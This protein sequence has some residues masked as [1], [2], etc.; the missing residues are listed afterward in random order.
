M[1]N[2]IYQSIKYGTNIIPE[3]EY[4]DTLITISDVASEMVVKT[5]G[6]FGKTT[7]LNDGTFTYP[8]KDGW[9]VLKTLMFQDPVFNVL[10][11]VLR[12]ISF[13]MVSKVGD[14]TTGAFVASNIFL[15]EVL[16]FLKNHQDVRQADMISAIKQVGDVLIKKIESSESVKTI[17]T[18]GDFSD[19]YKIAHVSSNRNDRISEIIQKIYQETKN[20]NIYVSMD[21]CESIDYEIQI[22]YKFDCKPIMQKLYRNTDDGTFYENNPCSCLIFDHN[23]NYQEHSQIIGTASSL[24]PNETVFIFAPHF[25][26]VIS[27]VLGSAIESFVQQGKVPNIMMIQVPLTNN[28]SRSLLSDMILL[29]NAQVFDYGKVRAF[30]AMVHNQ[31]HK[32]KIEDDLLNVAQYHFETTQDL[33]ASCMGKTRKIVVGRDYVLLKDYESVVNQQ[34]YQNTIKEL[35]EEYLEAKNK[36]DKSSTNLYKDYMNAHMHYTRLLGKL[37]AIKVGGASDLEKKYMKDVVDD[38]VLACKSAFTYG[39]TRGMNMTILSELYDMKQSGYSYTEPS[40]SFLSES[41]VDIFYNTYKRL[42]EMVMENEVPMDTVRGVKNPESYEAEKL[43]GYDIIDRCIKY[44][45]VYDIVSR[46]FYTDEDP[47]IV[48]SVKSDT[49]SIKAIISILTTIITS[50]Q[51]LT[52]NRN[53]DRTTGM[54]QRRE[55]A[56]K[57]KAEDYSYIASEVCEAIVKKLPGSILSN[58]LPK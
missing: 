24:R 55:T 35:E 47:I 45:W 40:L 17:D 27:N 52:I 11:Q 32:E 10:F 43:S 13:D 51:F 39:Y 7:M 20:P 22:G 16:N 12:Q 46:R 38:S 41:V 14:G 57:N 30:N 33:V 18:E 58:F 1:D 2:Q 31:T 3:E 56:V 4:I 19:I 42:S 29:T 25:D 28:L 53:Y 8:T 54:K 21:P 6:P 50:N 36:A 15:H 49:E 26:D 5:L 48:N 44:K 34:V 23:V 37:G 9:S